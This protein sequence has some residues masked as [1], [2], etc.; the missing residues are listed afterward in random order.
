[1]TLYHNEFDDTFVYLM[2]E[3]DE[4]TDDEDDPDYYRVMFVHG[5]KSLARTYH[6]YSENPDL[7]WVVKDINE[8][9]RIYL[10]VVQHEIVAEIDGD[11]HPDIE[12]IFATAN[13]MK[14]GE[15]D[16]VIS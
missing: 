1:M 4:S 5:R 14:K 6:D 12:A 10:A 2:D 3:R 11:H 16:W 9:I 15:A 8:A 7:E 13:D